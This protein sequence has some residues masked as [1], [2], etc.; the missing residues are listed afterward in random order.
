MRTILPPLLVALP[1]FVMGAARAAVVTID[2]ATIV[3]GSDGRSYASVGGKFQTASVAISG[4]QNSGSYALTL[5]YT[6]TFDGLASS[7]DDN[8]YYPDIFLRTPASSA[9]TQA[10]GYAVALGDEDSNGGQAAGFYAPDHIATSQSIWSG[11]N[12][13]TFGAAYALQPGGPAYAAPVVM[14]TGGEI[15]GTSVTTTTTD[16]HHMLAGYELYTMQVKISGL[17]AAIAASFGGGLDAFWGTGDCANGAFLATDGASP[18]FVA[19][20]EPGSLFYA[21][22]SLGIIISLRRR[23]RPFPDRGTLPKAGSA[24]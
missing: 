16:T 15:A 22:I 6:T 11:R 21:G 7:G 10:F 18:F 23:T 14:L 13:E 24:A 19:V 3:L 20:P 9:N 2:N 17:S 12:L 5:A 1:F 4:T 8:I